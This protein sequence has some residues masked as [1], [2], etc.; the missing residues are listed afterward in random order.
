M[1]TVRIPIQVE[2]PL[3]IVS[4]LPICFPI[5][6]SRIVALDR[7]ENQ[8]LDLF[9]LRLL[10]QE[11]DGN[12]VHIPVQFTP[13]QP[14]SE[15]GRLDWLIN[16]SGDCQRTFLLLL[17]LYDPEA[18]NKQSMQGSVLGNKIFD[19]SGQAEPLPYFPQMQAV[20]MPDSKLSI[21]R[22]G[23]EVFG[24]QY[25]TYGDHSAR[26]FFFPVIGPSGRC[27]T[28]IGHP[29]DPVGH[30]HHYSVW[31]AYHFINDVNFWSDDKTSGKQVHQRF[32]R[33]FDGPVLAGFEAVVDWETSDCQSI[34]REIKQARVYPQP[35][36][37]LL[38][39]LQFSFSVV[40]EIIKLN[41][42]SFG[43]LGVR[44]AKSMG[45]FDGSGLIR[46]SEGA[47][48]E[49]KIFHQPAL[50]CDYSGAI[51][52]KARNGI[53]IFDHP[54]NP[55]HP[56][57]WHVRSDGWMSPCHFLHH[58]HYICSDEMLQLNYRL[59]VH[60]GDVDDANV[61]AR[62]DQYARPP[63]IKVGSPD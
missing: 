54:D 9:S 34:M 31:L 62:Y 61:Q 16:S 11:K 45:V 21:Q 53:A 42:T 48:N 36:D 56:S 41:K 63:K 10:Q 6:F 4:D 39:D 13:Q 44:V 14:G 50:W 59:L 55:H 22:D 8:I 18:S 19:D 28:R 33:F 26:P 12:L 51:T 17:D 52:N 58:H 37:E 5:D 15:S 2:L 24:Y 57:H 30:H 23:A 35:D 40:N 32:S 1:K 27:L 20:P 60:N 49:Q 47:V 43:F 38:I 29:H 25:G 7:R 46:N 3:D